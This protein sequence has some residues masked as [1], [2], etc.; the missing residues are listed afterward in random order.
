MLLLRASSGGTLFLDCFQ[1]TQLSVFVMTFE[2]LSAQMLSKMP[3][4]FSQTSVKSRP[5]PQKGSKEVQSP[6]PSSNGYPLLPTCSKNDSKSAQNP[7]DFGAFRVPAVGWATRGL[8]NARQCHGFGHGAPGSTHLGA[9]ARSHARAGPR[10]A[11]SPAML[12]WAP[13]SGKAYPSHKPVWTT[14]DAP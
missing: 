4:P 12:L 3:A 11:V 13:E 7:K 1:N 2:N 9:P 5:S 6:A 10:S 14:L 8:R